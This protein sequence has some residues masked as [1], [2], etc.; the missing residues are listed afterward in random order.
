MVRILGT[1]CHDRRRIDEVMV[2]E[3]KRS[4]RGGALLNAA[5]SQPELLELRHSFRNST[6]DLHRGWLSIGDL[7][8]S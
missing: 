5:E 2:E 6:L 7:L 1:D 8:S 4:S 3:K